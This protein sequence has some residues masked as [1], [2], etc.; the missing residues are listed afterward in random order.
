MLVGSVND[1]VPAANGRPNY[2]QINLKP[3]YA[4]SIPAAVTAR[5][6]PS[7]V[8]AVSSVQLVDNGPGA[9]IRAGAHIPEDTRL[10]TVLFQTTISKLR[11]LLAAAGAS[12]DRSK[13]S[14]QPWPPPPTIAG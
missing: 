14:W 11:D 2:V 13:G 3:E 9:S 7:N 5:V 6:V 1:V 4:T 12:E 10:P 8:F